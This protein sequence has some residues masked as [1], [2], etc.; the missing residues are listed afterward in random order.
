MNRR[1][2]ITS[3][4][5]ASVALGSRAATG[6]PGGVNIAGLEFNP[7]KIPGQLDT[8]YVAP[9]AAEIAYYR[10]A[11]AR[12]LRIPFLWERAQPQIGGPLNEAY[13]RLLDSTIAAAGGMTVVLDAHQFGRR[14]VNGQQ[15]IIGES[16]AVP[17]AA[18]AHFWSAL[19]TRYRGNS[20]AVFNLQNEP[21]DQNTDTLVAVQNSTISAI[22]ATGARQLILVSGNA[23]SGAH[24]WVESGNARAMLAITDP[25]NHFA[26]DVHQY[27]DS[28]S[29]GSNGACVSGAPE[30]LAPFAA[31]ARQNQKRG[32]LGEFGAGG[33]TACAGELASLLDHVRAEA[34]VWAGWVYWAGGAWWPDTY[35]LSI[36]P[37]SIDHPVDRPQMRVLRRYFS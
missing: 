16:P 5:A 34:S 30:R 14:R 20:N 28:D 19:A 7:D 11:G 26:F 22:R 10:A 15:L 9:R 1:G 13:V 4:A 2:F 17:V 24:S 3:A 32:F 25:A 21:H 37:A 27:L 18:F 23:W 8:D 35:A 29:S 31:W 36:K 6:V 33:D 12:I